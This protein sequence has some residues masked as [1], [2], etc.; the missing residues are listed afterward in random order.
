MSVQ[1]PPD[2]VFLA[3]VH[4][5]LYSLLAGA[6]AITASIVT[7][8]AKR[9]IRTYDKR[10]ENLEAA[11]NTKAS[12]KDIE[13]AVEEIMG[14]RDAITALHQRI[15]VLYTHLVAKSKSDSGAALRN[16]S[17]GGN[18]RPGPRKPS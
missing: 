8:F 18:I 16:Q 9:M 17:S 15:D 12:A 1:T 6:L 2:N 7:F 14:V 13:F 3:W 11:M 5:W 4:D 10:L